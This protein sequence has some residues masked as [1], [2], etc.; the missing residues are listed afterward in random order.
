M[1]ANLYPR[2]NIRLKWFELK[3]VSFYLM[4]K[5]EISFS[6][7]SVENNINHYTPL[8][9]YIF[10]GVDKEVPKSDLIIFEDGLPS[11]YAKTVGLIGNKFSTEP[12]MDPVIIITDRIVELIKGKEDISREPPA[13]PNPRIKEIEV[14]ERE[15]SIKR[16]LTI[17]NDSSEI[18]DPFE[19]KLVETKDVRFIRSNPDPMKKD[20][21][22]YTWEFSIQPESNYTIE[23]QFQ[24]HIRK[25]FEIEKDPNLKNRTA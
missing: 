16:K 8:L 17:K 25:T 10:K 11:S 3:N 6:T 5:L 1:R 15:D 23:I 21:P 14:R 4:R 22:E 24:T 12:Q 18:I 13:Y 9:E 2:K 7:S 19:L 20:P